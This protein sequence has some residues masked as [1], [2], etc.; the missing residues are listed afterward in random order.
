VHYTIVVSNS[1]PSTAVGVPVTDNDLTG[2]AGWVSDSWTAVASGSSTVTTASGTGNISDTVTVVPGAGNAVTFTITAH[3]HPAAGS[4]SPIVNTA[5][6]TLP[7]GDTT[8]ADNT[9]SD[10]ITPVSPTSPLVHG[11]TATIGFWHNQNG[12]ALI[13]SLNGGST[14]TNLANWLA[15]NFP[16]LY[17]SHSS[18]NLTGKTN[19]DVADLFLQFFGVSGMKTDA[20]ILGG[21]LAVYVTNSNLA[22]NVAASYGFNVSSTGT[23]AKT[24]NVGSNGTAIGLQNN[25]SYTVFA[26]LQQANL[27]KQNGTFNANAFN[28]IFDGI[29]Q[30]GTSGKDRRAPSDVT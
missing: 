18:N 9:S 5:S 24:Y 17:G 22:G 6:V 30:G 7:N 26:L 13:N 29:N 28:D 25:T 12:Q 4:T 1:G 20:Q 10:T 19:A 11:D 14:A 23:G 2:L 15:T 27:D 16:Y 8:P 3:I 21:A